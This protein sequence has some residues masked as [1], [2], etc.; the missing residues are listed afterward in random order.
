MQ[1]SLQDPHERLLELLIGQCIAEGIHWTVGIA[2]EV[3]EHIQMLVGAR[4]IPAEALDQG[5]HMIRR[6][7]G[8][9]AAQDE[10]DGAERFAC[11]IL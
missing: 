10:G 4:R 1:I 11:T 7:A 9:K 6:P 2:E 8:H 3:R 5:Q